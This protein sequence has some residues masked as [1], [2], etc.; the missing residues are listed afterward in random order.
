VLRRVRAVVDRRFDRARYDAAQIV[1][2][3]SHELR[4][5]LDLDALTERLHRTAI[6]TVQPTAGRVWIRDRS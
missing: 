4:D 1:E 3:F 2:R 5:E 6:A